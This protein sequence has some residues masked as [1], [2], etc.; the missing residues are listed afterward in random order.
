MLTVCINGIIV[1]CISSI[2]NIKMIYILPCIKGDAHDKHYHFFTMGD[3]LTRSSRR[4]CIGPDG[5]LLVIDADGS[6]VEWFRPNPQLPEC[7]KIDDTLSPIGDEN[8]L[9]SRE[10]DYDLNDPDY[11]PYSDSDYDPEK[12]ESAELNEEEMELEFY[13]SSDEEDDEETQE[14]DRESAFILTSLYNSL[15]GVDMGDD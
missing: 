1:L 11:D 8:Y 6:L 5:I 4:I 9:Y 15:S 10:R 2:H 3:P 7:T 12:D 14:E 13:S